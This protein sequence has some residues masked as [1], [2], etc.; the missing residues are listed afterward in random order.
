MPGVYR[1][2]SCTAHFRASRKQCGVCG[3]SGIETDRETCPSCGT[4]FDESPFQQCPRC[5]SASI[6]R[7][8]RD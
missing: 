4:S 8:A 5:G 7:V 2:D 1:C 3:T 6:E